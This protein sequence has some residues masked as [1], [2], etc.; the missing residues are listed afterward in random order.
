MDVVKKK[1]L[2]SKAYFLVYG[3]LIC[4]ARH[5]GFTTYQDL[6]VLMGLPVQ[7]SYMGQE[8]AQMLGEISQNEVKQG[9]P[10]LT[11]LCVSVSGKPGQGFYQL[12]RD[13]GLLDGDSSEAEVGFWKA[14]RK[15]VWKTWKRDFGAKTF[16][17]IR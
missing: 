14:E 15:K 13:L 10:M 4:A 17:K 6:A 12:A 16:K 2:N 5:R 7:G 9:R 11:A 1:Y 8:I 3:E